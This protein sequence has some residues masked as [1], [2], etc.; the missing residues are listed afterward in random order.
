MSLDNIG[1][2]FGKI[3][4][5]GKTLSDFELDDITDKVNGQLALETISALEPPKNQRE[6]LADIL[7]PFLSSPNNGASEK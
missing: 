2:L 1:S 4:E 7:A 5:Q 6:H 3:K